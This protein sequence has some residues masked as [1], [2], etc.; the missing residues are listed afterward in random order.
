MKKRVLI[1]EEVL[2][3][4]KKE[5]LKSYPYEGCG[6]LGGKVEEEIFFITKSWA[7]T[8]AWPFPEERKRRFALDPKEFLQ[9]EREAKKMNIEIVGIYHSHPNYP[10]QPSEFDAQ[11]AWEGYLYLIL[12]LISEKVIDVKAYQWRDVK[13]FEEIDWESVKS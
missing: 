13:G 3:A 7:V 4:I 10:A 5:V 9:T 6:L 2:E 11:N 1:L 8:N 12:S